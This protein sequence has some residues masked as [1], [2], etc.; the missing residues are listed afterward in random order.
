MASGAPE[1]L[2]FATK[3]ALERDL[4]AAALDTGLPCAFVLADALYRSDRRLRICWRRVRSP[5]CFRSA[6]T[7]A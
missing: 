2:A 5:T 1:A 3:P 4:I 7:S 6:A